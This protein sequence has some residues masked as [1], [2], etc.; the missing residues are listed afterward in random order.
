M[1]LT[2]KERNTC[3]ALLCRWAARDNEL[4]ASD[5][6]S[7]SQYYDLMGA[8]TALRTLGL[9]AE[10]VLSDAPAPG[11]YYNF[12]KIMLDGMVYDVPEPKEEMENEDA[13]DPPAQR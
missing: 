11:G 6:Y 12:G 3:A 5:L 1:K 9:M 2:D 4:M 7:S 13:D 10:T 8:L